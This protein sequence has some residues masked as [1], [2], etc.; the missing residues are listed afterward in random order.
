MPACNARN[1]RSAAI[2]SGISW[3]MGQPFAEGEP[4]AFRLD[5]PLNARQFRRPQGSRTSFTGVLPSIHEAARDISFGAE[6]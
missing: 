6:S 4:G 3:A 5:D 2:Y 1:P